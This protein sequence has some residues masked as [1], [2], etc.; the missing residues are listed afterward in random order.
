LNYTV[1]FILIIG[2]VGVVSFFAA[3]VLIPE[4]NA[5]APSRKSAAKTLAPPV[6]HGGGDLQVV[7]AD[8]K[9]ADRPI[10]VS[11]SGPFPHDL[12]SLTPVANAPLGSKPNPLVDTK[13][14]PPA[15]GIA[16]A[17]ETKAPPADA[18]TLPPPV[19]VAAPAASASPA[20]PKAV[21]FA[22]KTDT[23]P[24][25]I[26]SPKLTLTGARIAPP[27]TMAARLDPK[28]P[29]V[30]T[31]PPPPA[32]P[33]AAVPKTTAPLVTITATPAA[34]P[35]DTTKKKRPDANAPLGYKL[36]SAAVCA[37]VENRAPQGVGDRFSKESGAVYYF[38]H[39]V[40]ATDSA[41]VMHKW[42]RDG[43]LIQTSI[44]EI[45]SP[46]WRTHSKRSFLTMD[47]PTGSWKVDVVDQRTG[48]VLESNSFVIT[49]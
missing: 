9:P 42:Y 40:G 39:L 43:K 36:A 18:K 44:L 3:S 16:A 49:E 26:I 33:A 38:T 21:A 7:V 1:K 11:D 30:E 19:A 20:D 24:A 2:I 47:D 8:D 46:N 13:A 35:P 10:K 12:E 27:N 17:P 4:K 15:P 25:P 45:K 32:P 6:F 23:A 41:A 5:V 37:G 28:A 29:P 14:A 34:T 48:K 22:A 31:P